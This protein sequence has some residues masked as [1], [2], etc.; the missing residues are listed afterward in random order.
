MT[1]IYMSVEGMRVLGEGHVEDKLY[2]LESFLSFRYVG[3]GF[4]THIISFGAKHLFP[5]S[6]LASSPH[7]DLKVI[8]SPM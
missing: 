8:Y 5:L 1:F 4:R 7:L 3:P 6:P 2:E